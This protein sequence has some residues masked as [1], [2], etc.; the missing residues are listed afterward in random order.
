MAAASVTITQFWDATKDSWV[1]APPTIPIGSKISVVASIQN[2]SA[3]T[4]NLSLY[5]VIYN[6]DGS[7]CSDYTFNYGGVIAGWYSDAEILG[8][9]N[10]GGVYKADAY[11][12]V[13]G[14]LV[15]SAIAVTI[16]TVQAGDGGDGTKTWL[17]KYWWVFPVG[18]GLL[19]LAAKLSRKRK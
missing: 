6:P 7:V 12:Y 15:A 10:Q 1:T 11:A 8:W 5:L 3:T 4:E 13:D 18:G 2:T 16:A 19:V 17:D 14:T 9:A